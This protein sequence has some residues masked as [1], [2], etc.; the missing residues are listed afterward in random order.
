M[1]LFS[2]FH[3]RCVR[4]T[5]FAIVLGVCG[6]Y[7]ADN[8]HAVKYYYVHPGLTTG[9]GDGTSWTNAWKSLM[10]VNWAQLGIDA[11]TQ[12]VYLYIKKGTVSPD[13]ISPGAGN[14]GSSDVNRVIVTTDPAD[15]G[16][17]PIITASKRITGPWANVSGEVYSAPTGLTYDS[18]SG[19]QDGTIQLFKRTTDANVER[20]EYYIDKTV[21][22]YTVYVRM[23]DGAHPSTHT[24]DLNNTRTNVYLYQTDFFTIENVNLWYGG[25]W[26]VA[27]AYQSGNVTMRNIT[28]RNCVQG[29]I[30]MTTANSVF[31]NI[32]VEGCWN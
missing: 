27:R 1:L 14:G 2:H 17:N 13:R 28:V 7:G 10:S 22:P 3:V 9:L 5:I 30:G 21:S 31:D 4:L 23:T 11:D 8:V 18:W 26:G 12:P 16:D 15:T 20:G 19:W 29:L 32:D 24:L 6:L 25:E